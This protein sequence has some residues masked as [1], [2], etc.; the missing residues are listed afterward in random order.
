MTR[1]DLRLKTYK[2]HM[3]RELWL[4][5]EAALTALDDLRKA[6][7]STKQ[8]SPYQAVW[9]M[10]ARLATIQKQMPQ[11]LRGDLT[12]PVPLGEAEAH[13]EASNRSSG[14]P[15]ASTHACGDWAGAHL[16]A[17]GLQRRP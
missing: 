17:F 6:L 11:G 13:P 7:H 9:R 14:L 4:K 1:Y 12:R 2:T 10:R 3:D 16:R 5:F 8:E 15:E